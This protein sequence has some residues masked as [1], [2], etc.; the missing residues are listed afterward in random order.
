MLLWWQ[1][2][3]QWQ[4]WVVFS[5]YVRFTTNGTKRPWFKSFTEV[6]TGFVSQLLPCN[7]TETFLTY[8]VWRQT[9]THSPALHLPRSAHL[10]DSRQLKRCTLFHFYLHMYSAEKREL[11]F[12]L[13]AHI[14]PALY[15]KASENYSVFS[16]FAEP[17]ICKY[18]LKVLAQLLFFMDKVSLFIV[19][20]L[21]RKVLI[22]TNMILDKGRWTFIKDCAQTWSYGL[23]LVKSTSSWSPGVEYVLSQYHR[24]SFLYTLLTPSTT[25]RTISS[26][27]TIQIDFKIWATS[28]MHLYIFRFNAVWKRIHA[29]VKLRDAHILV[30]VPWIWLSPAYKL[31]VSYSSFAMHSL[32]ER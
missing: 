29:P 32:Y 1:D 10:C 31:F 23:F 2:C 21:E 9:S 27:H 16:W 12:L 28:L 15:C 24:F 22:S 25:D 3:T 17:V 26:R 13:N 11:T 8:S 5:H 4:D 30:S 7:S 20:L 19:V 6:Y 14:P 18:T